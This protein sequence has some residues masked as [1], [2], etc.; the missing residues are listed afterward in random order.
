MHP[1]KFHYKDDSSENLP[2]IFSQPAVPCPSF[3][4][5]ISLPWV[6]GAAG[7]IKIC[8]ATTVGGGEKAGGSF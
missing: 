3:L 6:R 7:G 1:I 8:M 5:L 2:V 4:T